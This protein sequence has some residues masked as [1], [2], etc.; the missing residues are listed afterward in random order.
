MSVI[1]KIVSIHE[2]YIK[3]KECFLWLN[4]VDSTTST[5]QMYD[6]GANMTV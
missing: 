1:V 5:A 6:S 3:V 4:S 2:A